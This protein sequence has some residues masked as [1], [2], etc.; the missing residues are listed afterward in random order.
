V[1]VYQVDQNAK[2]RRSRKRKSSWVQLE[3]AIP[4]SNS[5]EE[6]PATLGSTPGSSCSGS[7][8]QLHSNRSIPTLI[9]IRGEFRLVID[10][11]SSS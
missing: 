9:M 2:W 7:C 4:G 1:D 3:V 11:R 6:L 5:R 8:K 10:L